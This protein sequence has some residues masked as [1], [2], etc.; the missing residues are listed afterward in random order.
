LPAGSYRLRV[1]L[2]DGAGY[3]VSDFEIDG[4]TVVPGKTL[5]LNHRVF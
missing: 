1:Q 4:V 5:F 3:I 2:I